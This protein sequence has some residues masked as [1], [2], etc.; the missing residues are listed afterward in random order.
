MENFFDNLCR[1]LA[2]PMPRKRALK[3]I[4]GGFAGVIFAP[5]AFGRSQSTPVKKCSPNCLCTG[6]VKGPGCCAPGQ[7][8]WGTGSTQICC[9]A[10][11]VGAFVVK[12][13]K[14]TQ[15]SCVEYTASGTYPSNTTPLSQGSTCS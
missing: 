11:H 4:A 1:S 5:F 3:I 14:K 2:A 13:D 8:C 6:A 7:T 9:D 15:I 10:G 12:P